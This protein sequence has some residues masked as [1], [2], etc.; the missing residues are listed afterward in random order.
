[1]YIDFL[2]N[3]PHATITAAYSVRSKPGGTV[4]MPLHFKPVFGK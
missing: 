3:R 4:S 2:Q 1:M